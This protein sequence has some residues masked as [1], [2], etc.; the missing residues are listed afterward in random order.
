MKIHEIKT[1]R[2]TA[3]GLRERAKLSTTEADQ[4]EARAVELEKSLTKEERSEL[5]KP[6]AQ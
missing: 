5:T 2:S 6:A 3:R 1:L 4:L